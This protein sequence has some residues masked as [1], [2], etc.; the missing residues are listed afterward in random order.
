MQFVSIYRLKELSCFAYIAK[1]QIAFALV[2]K[3]QAG[4]ALALLEYLEKGS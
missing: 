4:V 2:I 3:L 1:Q